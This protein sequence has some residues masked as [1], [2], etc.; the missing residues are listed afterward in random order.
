[1]LASM[2]PWLETSRSLLLSGRIFKIFRVGFRSQQSGKSGLFDVLE[3]KDWVNVIATTNDGYTFLVKQ[4][5]YGSREVTLEFPAGTV[6]EGQD[7]A[8][9]AARELAEETGGTSPRITKLGAS[10]P[11]PAIQGNTCHHFLA[12]NV[13]ITQAV[14]LDEHEEIE[15]VRV[16]LADVDRLITEGAITHA[17]ALVTW[18]FYQSRAS[19][20]SP[21]PRP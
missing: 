2:L 20:A 14:S 4:F 17:L 8:S 11:N 5:R 6:E 21:E 18:H 7:P 16:P 9:T 12:E 1:M 3:T 10:R 13:E 19:A 15:L